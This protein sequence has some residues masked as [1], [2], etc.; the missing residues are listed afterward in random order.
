[1]F[2]VSLYKISPV[3]RSI[4]LARRISVSGSDAKN[5]IRRPLQISEERMAMA[6]ISLAVMVRRFGTVAVL[7]RKSLSACLWWKYKDEDDMIFA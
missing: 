3:I 6:A 4:C 5:G 7:M 2:F 1:M